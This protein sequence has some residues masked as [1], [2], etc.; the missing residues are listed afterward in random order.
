MHFPSADGVSTSD[1]DSEER[2]GDER[3]RLSACGGGLCLVNMSMNVL[4]K[5]TCIHRT[6]REGWMPLTAEGPPPAGIPGSAS[7][8]STLPCVPNTRS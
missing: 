4:N 8:S 6:L 1:G 7:R 5:D 2:D 3:R